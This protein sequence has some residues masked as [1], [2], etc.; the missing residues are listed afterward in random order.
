[1]YC[2]FGASSQRNDKDFLIQK[3]GQVGNFNGHQEQR[4]GD[5]SAF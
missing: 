2:K 1:M 3:E 5:G 4:R